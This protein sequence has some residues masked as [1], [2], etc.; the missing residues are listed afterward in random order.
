MTRA[1]VLWRGDRSVMTRAR[2]CVAYLSFPQSMTAAE[3]VERR[4]KPY[5]TW[6]FFYVSGGAER[7]PTE[8][9]ERGPGAVRGTFI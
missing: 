9:G 6:P 4:Q 1:A 8:I 2:Q 7:M 3:A 5:K